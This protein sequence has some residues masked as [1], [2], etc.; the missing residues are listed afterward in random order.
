VTNSAT[1]VVGRDAESEIN[2]LR[3][4]VQRL[5]VKKKEMQKAGQGGGFVEG[6]L[7]TEKLSLQVLQST[8]YPQYY[9]TNAPCLQSNMDKLAGLQSYLAGMNARL[10]EEGGDERKRRAIADKV[11][12]LQVQPVQTVF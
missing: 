5:G 12:G 1:V 3:I 4:Q 6:C 2:A 11:G 9:L 8:V 10:V 7:P